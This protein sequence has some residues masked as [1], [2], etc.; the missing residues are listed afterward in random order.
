MLCD[1]KVEKTWGIKDFGQ[2]LTM[3]I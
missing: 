3:I 1:L 2:G